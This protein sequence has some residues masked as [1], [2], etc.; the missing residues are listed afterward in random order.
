MHAQLVFADA[1]LTCVLQAEHAWLQGSAHPACTQLVGGL[2]CSSAAHEAVF[3]PDI[4]HPSTCK[5]IRKKRN[6]TTTP[7]G[8]N[9]LRSQVLYQAAQNAKILHAGGHVRVGTTSHAGQ[10]LLL[11]NKPSK[12]KD[13]S[14]HKSGLCCAVNRVVCRAT[15]DM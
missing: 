11:C 7:F 2:M 3:T 13:E 4:I 8:R 1:L 10:Y 15:Q 12:N 5:G 14:T 6:E 9:L